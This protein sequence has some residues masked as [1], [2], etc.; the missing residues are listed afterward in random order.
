MPEVDQE[1]A[2]FVVKALVEK[3]DKVQIKRTV[4]ERGVLLELMV[5]PEDM[6]KI[7]GKE[8]KT[9]NALRTL[10]KVLGSKTNSRVNLKIA[11]PEGGA[12]KETA[13]EVSKEVSKEEDETEKGQEESVVE[14]AKESVK[15]L[16]KEL[17]E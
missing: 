5:D 17:E 2:E 14:E 9:V 15:E 12:P 1:F 13:K 6:G 16:E 7:I 11:E 10:L 4:D 8:G 3:P